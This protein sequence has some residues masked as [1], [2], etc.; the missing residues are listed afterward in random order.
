MFKTRQSAAR[1]FASAATFVSLALFG[2]G[3]AT[4]A[5]KVIMRINFTPWAMHA[6]YFGGRAQGFYAQEGIELEIRPPSSGQQNEVFIG[7]GREQ[8]GVTNA[9]AFVKARGSGIPIVAVM[10]DQ[11][12]NPFA[13]ISL[14]KSG[15]TGPE[16]LKGAKI[17]WFPANVVGMLDPVLAK[18]GLTR[19][20]VELVNV[21]RGAEVQM[22]AA[23][24]VDG[25]FG[26]S[27]GQALTLE[28]RGFPVNVMPVRDYGVKFY[29]TVVYTNDALLKSSPDLVKRF[30]RATMKSLIWAHDNVEAAMQEIVKVSPDR[31]LKLESRKLRM[32]YDLYNVPDYGERFGKMTDAKWQSSID[33]LADSGDLP[34]KPSPKEMYTNAIV[35]SLDEARTLSTL[36]K[37]AAK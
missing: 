9:D 28:M 22:L 1:Q 25:L 18:G 16:K 3:A 35:E 13:V 24:Q 20:D 29:G 34:K 6:Q 27:F 14:K 2:A 32:I 5:D 31:D 36:I 11:P 7:S 33:I 37:R 23:G 19:K 12:D 15:I 17:A 30:V 4:A 26:Y 10:A 8:F 21:A